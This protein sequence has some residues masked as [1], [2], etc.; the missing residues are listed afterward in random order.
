MRAGTVVVTVVV[1]IIGYY[2]WVIVVKGTVF[3]QAVVIQI[4][5]IGGWCTEVVVFSL[6]FRG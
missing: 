2:Y 5:F 4:L 3:V 1:A 6:F